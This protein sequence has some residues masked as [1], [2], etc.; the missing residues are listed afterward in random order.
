MRRVVKG[1]EAGR[2]VGGTSEDGV[3]AQRWT[4]IY[5][6]LRDAIVSHR[7]S[8]GAKLAEEELAA[9]YSVSRT[10]IR[11]ALQALA[12]DRLVTLELNRGAFVA[13]PTTEE[14]L[15][16]F[17]ARA[18]IEPGVASMAARRATDADIS[19]LRLRLKEEAETEAE[20][21]EGDSIQMSAQFHLLI[22]DIS[23]QEILIGFVRELL[24]QSSLII[25]LYWK[26][27]ETTCESHAHGALVD[28]LA[29]H[30]EEE[31]AEIMRAHIAD[32]KA[33]LDLTPKEERPGSLADILGRHGPARG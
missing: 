23:R 11:A 18:L 30:K 8:P 12:H 6:A 4:A 5:L 20:R 19:R 13:K 2:A 3:R 10:I 31:A 14:A 1:R 29:A 7:L 21:S 32:L 15:Q 17:E 27:R 24:S 22:A 28:A 9:I 33:G 25:S 16:V 26:R